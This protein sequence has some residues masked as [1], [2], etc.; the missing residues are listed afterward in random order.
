MQ[1]VRTT[2]TLP[3]ELH[4]ELRL[5]A[6]KKRKTFTSIVTDTLKNRRRY[7]KPTR[8]TIEKRIKAAFKIFDEVAN[9]GLDIDLV[10]ALR[11]E[12]DRDN[13]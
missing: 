11:E 6:I 1:L 10:K 9:S 2:I 4:E 12:R 8:A 3:R 7:K 5:D 13:A